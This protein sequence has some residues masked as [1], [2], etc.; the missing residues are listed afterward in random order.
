MRTRAASRKTVLALCLGVGAALG[1]AGADTA[2]DVDAPDPFAP[3]D[4]TMTMDATQD[5]GCVGCDADN[6]GGM[7]AARP[8]VALDLGA[9]GGDGPPA[10]PEE[11]C[12]NGLDDNHD[13]Q[14]DEDCAC[15]PGAEH[16]CF[17]GPLARAGVGVCVWGTQRCVGEGMEGVWSACTGA[18]TPASTEACDGVDNTCDGTVDEGCGCPSMGASR[19]CYGGAAGTV[20]R[21]TCRAGRQMCTA[22]MGGAVWGPCVGEVVPDIERCDGMDR[23]CD[24]SPTNGCGCEVGRATT[25]YDGPTGTAGVGVCHTGAMMCA[26]LPG[27][28]SGM[29]DCLG[30]VEPGA[31]DCSD[32]VDGDCDGMVDCLDSDCAGHPACVTCRMGSATLLQPREAEVVLVV[33]KSGSMAVRGTDGATRWVALRS[34]L[35]RVLPTLDGRIDMGLMMFP[36]SGQCGVPVGRLTVPIRPMNSSTLRA[37]TR[38][39][40]PTG[41]TPTTAALTETERYLGSTPTSRPRYLVLATDGEP[42]CGGGVSSVVSRL[43]EI[44]SRGIPT[45]VLGL[46]GASS[47]LRAALNQMAT[48]GGR[49]RPGGTAFYEVVNTEQFSA[50]MRAISAA[51]SGCTYALDAPPTNPATLRILFNGMEVTRDAANGWSFVDSTNRQ[52]RF[53]GAACTRL[54]AGTVVNVTALDNCQ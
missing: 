22:A 19:E 46:P 44:N 13:G 15:V 41:N 40:R 17:V 2:V 29:T 24:G 25:C 49:P 48:A 33:D 28:G 21:G 50:A 18:G 6:D 12:G 30:G 26:V 32:R 7:D 51:G 53:N 8:D 47:T 35:D 31:E 1:C 36:A 37:L 10:I 42:N 11:I 16:P 52:V 39:Y 20:G 54:G 4:A 43:M 38:V 45:F 34:A 9:D 14:A 5:R 3:R 27:G 23:D